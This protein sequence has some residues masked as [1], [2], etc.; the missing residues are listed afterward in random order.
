M[1]RAFCLF[2]AVLKPVLTAPLQGG[3]VHHGVTPDS[4]MANCRSRS[5]PDNAFYPLYQSVPLTVLHQV[6]F[7]PHILHGGAVGRGKTKTTSK[8]GLQ[9]MQKRRGLLLSYGKLPVDLDQRMTLG[10]ISSRKGN[11]QRQ[12]FLK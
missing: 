9:E 1:P 3:A 8:Y 7:L 12:V 5:C 6:I 4:H 11:F 10:F 2:K